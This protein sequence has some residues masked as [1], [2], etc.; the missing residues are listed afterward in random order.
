MSIFKADKSNASN[1]FSEVIGDVSSNKSEKANSRLESILNEVSDDSSVSVRRTESTGGGNYRRSKTTNVRVQTSRK[2]DRYRTERQCRTILPDVLATESIENMLG[3]IENSL[4]LL[5]SRLQR[6]VVSNS[7][8]I[9]T[10]TNLTGGSEVSLRETENIQTEHSTV[11]M[12]DNINNSLVQE[13]DVL[14]DRIQSE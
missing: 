14:I 4:A 2:T 8:P 11:G 7:L 10:D 5:D 13:I 12:A 1:H 6:G 3:R 9:H